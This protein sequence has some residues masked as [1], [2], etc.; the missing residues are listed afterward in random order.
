MLFDTN[1]IVANLDEAHEHHDWSSAIFQQ[2][3][4]RDILLPAHALSEAFNRLT[5]GGTSGQFLPD[6]TAVALRDL[7]TIAAVRALDAQETIDAVCRF[8]AKGGRGAR[9]YD[10]LIGYVAVVERVGR[11]VT[12][13][14]RDLRPLF[15]DLEVLTPKEAIGS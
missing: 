14:V 3:P 12:W 9:L 2:T 1:V 6:Q 11:I 4:L 7:G 15:T 13:N 5:R 10:Y 8:A